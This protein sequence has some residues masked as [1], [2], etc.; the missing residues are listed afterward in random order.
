MKNSAATGGLWHLRDC[1]E[2]VGGAIFLPGEADCVGARD[3]RNA[4]VEHRPSV[5][6]KC[7]CVDEVL[8]ALRIARI[9]NLPVSV[10]GGGPADSSP[11]D[12]GMVLDI[13]GMQHDT[14]S[15][16]PDDALHHSKVRE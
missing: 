12:E 3:T 15:G 2:S 16:A 10:L 8:L 9:R 4:A 6:V 11:P 13:S 1:I 5:T 14:P 7:R